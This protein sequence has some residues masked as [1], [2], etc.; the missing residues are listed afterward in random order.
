MEPG[1][2]LSVQWPA[3]PAKRV[4]ALS[5]LGPAVQSETT[6]SRVCVC[7]ASAWGNP[8]ILDLQ[9]TGCR[10]ASAWERGPI[11]S[12]CPSFMPC[13]A[14]VSLYTAEAP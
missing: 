8:D 12:R 7:T 4:Q 11:N 2:V 6:V 9:L 1:I 13:H 14:H 3:V 5:I 10:R